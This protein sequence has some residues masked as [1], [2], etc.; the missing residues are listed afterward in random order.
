MRK[1]FTLI[2]LL[3]VIA[4]IAILAAILLPA[5]NKARARAKQI[6]CLSQLKQIHLGAC[7]YAEDNA[8]GYAA[9]G[10]RYPSSLRDSLVEYTRNRK[11]FYCLSYV[12][13]NYAGY[14]NELIDKKPIFKVFV[15]NSPRTAD[16]PGQIDKQYKVA[17]PSGTT[18]FWEAWGNDSVVKVNEH[19]RHGKTMNVVYLD[20]HAV[21]IIRPR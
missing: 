14:G 6:Q 12:E 7:S 19:W 17:T 10:C 21:N 15:Q 20:G 11:V 9:S 8:A 16:I 3:V 1:K 2:E 5:L 18:L 4:I 13:N